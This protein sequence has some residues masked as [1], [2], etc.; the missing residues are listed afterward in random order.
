MK[1]LGSLFLAVCFLAAGCGYHFVGSGGRAPGGIK[2]LAIPTVENSSSYSTLTTALTNDLIHLFIL[3]NSVN[4]TFPDSADAVLAVKITAVNIEG[5]ARNR[6][7][8]ASASRRVAVVVQA[9]LTR[10]GDGK[11]IWESRRVF[12]RRTYLVVEDQSA[13]EANMKTAMTEA[14]QEIAEKIH[15][16]FFEDY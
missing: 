15:D 5:V 1:R 13:L 11:I 8:D 3:S 16:N 7:R 2:K 4:L 14:A 6:A 9:K 10:V 12:G